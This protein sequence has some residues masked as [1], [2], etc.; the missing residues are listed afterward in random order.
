MYY[1]LATSCCCSA[2][3]LLIQKHVKD[4]RTTTMVTILSD[5]E[6]VNELARMLSGEKVTKLTKEH[7]EELLKMAQE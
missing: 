5:K 4:E 1:S 7:A 2:T 6:R 3:P